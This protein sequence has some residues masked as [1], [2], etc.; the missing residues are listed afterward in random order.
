MQ[1]LSCENEV[2][3]VMPDGGEAIKYTLRNTS[4]GLSLTLTNYG[5]TIIS[6]QTADRL[7]SIEEITL[8][9]RDLPSIV[10]H[11]SYYGCAVGRVC[12][13]ISKG[14]FTLDGGSTFHKLAINNGPN[15]LHGGIQGF[16][17]KLWSFKEV[18]TDS[19]VGVEFEYV[20]G[21]CEENYPGCVTVRINRMLLMK[22]VSKGTYRFS[23]GPCC[24]LTYPR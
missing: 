16:D 4:T 22:I 9:W 12:N 10:K 6:I 20:S 7:G 8:N 5:A 11:T 17:K 2:F 14:T 15:H 13:R 18:K 1:N 3:G 21:D 19:S 23:L 24:V